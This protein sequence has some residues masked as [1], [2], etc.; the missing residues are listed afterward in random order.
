MVGDVV[1]LEV[2]SELGDDGVVDVALPVGRWAGTG[3]G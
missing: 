3:V 1:E 2:V